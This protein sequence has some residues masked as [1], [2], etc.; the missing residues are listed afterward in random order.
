MNLRST[1][2]RLGILLAKCWSLNK[3]YLAPTPPD[4]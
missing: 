2:Y 4:R 1:G 3:H